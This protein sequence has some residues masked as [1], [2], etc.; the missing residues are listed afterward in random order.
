MRFL[1]ILISDEVKVMSVGLCSSYGDNSCLDLETV[2][3]NPESSDMHV[4]GDLRIIV[5]EES[6]Y[7]IM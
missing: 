4:T 5:T 1:A 7:H 6:Q 3:H 2:F